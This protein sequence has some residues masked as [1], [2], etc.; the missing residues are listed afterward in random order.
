MTDF[1]AGFFFGSL[2]S[3]V[4]GMVLAAK[5][6]RDVQQ[7]RDDYVTSLQA[8]RDRWNKLFAEERQKFIGILK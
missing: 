7:I 3:L 6:K 4:A 1:L 8:E 5:A 2:F